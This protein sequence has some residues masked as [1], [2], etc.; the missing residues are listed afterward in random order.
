EQPSIA[1]T[2]LDDNSWEADGLVSLTD[3]ERGV[4]L[5]VD[6]TLDANTL[7]GLFMQRLARMPEPGDEITEAGFRLRVVSL[8]EHRVGK[9]HVLRIDEGG[10]GA[11]AEALLSEQA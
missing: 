8:E 3:L 9:V 2:L 7:S 5:V 11:A 1:I 6:E 4:G 10:A